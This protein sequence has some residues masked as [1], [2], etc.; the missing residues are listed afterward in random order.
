MEIIALYKQNIDIVRFAWF[1]PGPPGAVVADGVTATVADT[2]VH[3]H[4]GPAL[5]ALAQ[6]V[7]VARHVDHAL[8]GQAASWKKKDYRVWF[9]DFLSSSSSS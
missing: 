9:R 2:G 4:V 8:G 7:V 6:R 1:L 3:L 5:T